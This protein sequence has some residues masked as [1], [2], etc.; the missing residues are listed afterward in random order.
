MFEKKGLLLK[1]GKHTKYQRLLSRR[2]I[3]F[4]VLGLGILFFL[5]IYSLKTVGNH[6]KEAVITTM[7]GEKVTKNQPLNK[8]LSY[9]V[10]YHWKVKRYWPIKAG[11]KM[12][13]SLPSNV[14]P[15]AGGLSFGVK[16]DAGKYIGDFKINQGAKEGILTF[17][18]YCQKYRKK[19]LSGMLSFT[20]NGKK[21]ERTKNW[22]INQVAWIDEEG[23]PTWQIVFNPNKKV[24]THTYITNV[25]VGDQV[26][27]PNSITLSYGHIN[28][29]GNFVAEET[30]DTPIK[31]HK[32]KIEG[33]N[34]N[35]L[36]IPLHKVSQTVQV[37]YKTKL[38]TERSV[39]L[40]NIAVATSNEC[41]KSSVTASLQ[42]DGR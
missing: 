33:E 7:E 36:V 21:E 10:H 11:T 28:L 13:F 41:K 16:N 8:Y 27:D 37:T 22:M 12:K 19:T 34:D 30:F 40:S 38:M 15:N 20:V 42:L 6:A 2:I 4:L 23:N 17:N 32:I 9:T 5:N 35:T 29:I 1:K 14:T 25:R 24:L 26:Y 39:N 31:D 18:D 3:I